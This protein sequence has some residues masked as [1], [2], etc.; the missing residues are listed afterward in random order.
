M[1]QSTQ[2]NQEIADLLRASDVGWLLEG[3]PEAERRVILAEIAQAIRAAEQECEQR[4]GHSVDLNAAMC[5]DPESFK[6][7]I[8]TFVLPMTAPIRAMVYCVLSG[9]RIRHL[10]Y[11]YEAEQMSHLK[12]TVAF[13]DQ[14]IDFE[15]A[16]HWDAEVLHHL[17]FAKV[18]NRPLIDGYYAFRT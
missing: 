16:E 2:S 5:D 3:K 1:T 15:S 7:L 6:P 12:V 8:Q 18:G 11:T 10:S 13:P 17:G 9:A 4:L 14:S